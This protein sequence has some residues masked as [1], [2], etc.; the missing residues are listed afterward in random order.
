MLLRFAFKTLPLFL[1]LFSSTICFGQVTVEEVKLSG[2]FYWGEGF[3]A[4]RQEA[5][6]RAR[7]DLIER[8]VVVIISESDRVVRED[9][10]NLTSETE[11][12]SRSVSRMR[13]RGLD[14]ISVQQRDRERTWRVTA[15]ISKEMFEES[16]ALEKEQLLSKL[17]ES[18]RLERS[19]RL[20]DAVPLYQEIIAGSRFFPRPVYSDAS[21]HGARTE[22]SQF[23]RDR[24]N[25]FLNSLEIQ[26][27]DVRTRSTESS[28]EKYFDLSVT[29]ENNPVSNI[30]IGLDRSGYASHTVMNGAVSLFYDR[31]PDA[32]F[33]QFPISIEPRLADTIADELRDVTSRTIP[34][35]S[36]QL[37]VD[38]GDIIQIDFT[39]QHLSDNRFRFSPIVQNLSVFDIQWDFGDGNASRQNEPVHAYGRNDQSHV[40]TLT[41]NQ[42][43]DLRIQKRV[44]PDGSL[45][46]ESEHSRTPEPR[47]AVRAERSNTYDVPA[48]HTEFINSILGVNSGRELETLLTRLNRSGHIQHGRRADVRRPSESYIVIIDPASLSIHALLSPV[49]RNERTNLID[50][51]L[52]NNAQLGDEFRGFGSIWIEFK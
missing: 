40:V 52:I 5:V 10:E 31:T 12:R 1:L 15:Y 29:Y 41:I 25:H 43:P 11:L 9:N 8:I 30:A 44:Q 27:K 46:P 24:I 39:A 49:R 16:L 22:I 51:R 7:Q 23:S 21:R 19:G 47:P 48:G 26:F 14:Y 4:D 32:R 18:L 6:E 38:F 13:L 20:P 33:Q 28:I 35:R 45:T 3:S 2:N 17:D 34:R 37:T 36:D 50:Q 42:S